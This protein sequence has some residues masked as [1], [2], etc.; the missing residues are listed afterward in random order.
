MCGQTCAVND[1]VPKCGT[2]LVVSIMASLNVLPN[3]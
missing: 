3:L 2:K 1:G